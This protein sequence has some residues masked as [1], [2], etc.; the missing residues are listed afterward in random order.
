MQSIHFQEGEFPTLYAGHGVSRDPAPCAASTTVPLLPAHGEAGHFISVD[1]SQPGI[2]AADL[3]AAYH[4]L[5]CFPDLDYR[6]G[7]RL[8]VEGQLNGS[9]VGQVSHD[10]DHASE[11]VP[12][13]DTI[14]YRNRHEICL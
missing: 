5:R 12:C 1:G 3:Q 4:L 13:A 10:R 11:A 7:A 14:H 8:Q 9:L 6:V 2:T